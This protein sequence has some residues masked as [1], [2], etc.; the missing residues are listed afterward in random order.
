MTTLAARR[1]H[2]PFWVGVSAG[3][4]LWTVAWFVAL[5]LSTW[6]A[7]DLLGLDPASMLAAHRSGEFFAALGDAVVTGPTRTNVNDFRA[8]LIAGRDHRW[9]G[10]TA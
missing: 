8:I 9:F 10:A 4:A 1:F 5:P 7:F 2:V 3:A 6:V